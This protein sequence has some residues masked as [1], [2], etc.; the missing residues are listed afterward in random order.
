MHYKYILFVYDMSL[1]SVHSA[2][3]FIQV[4]NFLREENLL[5]LPYM[6][7]ASYVIVKI[8]FLALHCSY[9]AF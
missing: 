3:D 6:V 7:C 4:L 9:I 5:I 8:F 2:F 1:N